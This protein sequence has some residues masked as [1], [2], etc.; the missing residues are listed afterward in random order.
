MTVVRREQLL[1]KAGITTARC[2]GCR[3][4]FERDRL[5]WTAQSWV[6]SD[7]RRGEFCAALCFDCARYAW[8]HCWRCGEL[9]AR[10]E[11]VCD[12]CEERVP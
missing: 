4:L 12:R 5:T 7:L 1:V 3:R 8:C 10:L 6:T 11:G 9:T 2:D